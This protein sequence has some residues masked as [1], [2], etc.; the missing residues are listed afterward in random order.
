MRNTVL[1]FT[2]I[3][4]I[5][6]TL[7][8][9]F[10]GS[11]HATSNTQ[12][13]AVFFIDV[14]QGDCSIIACDG[15]IMM[16]DTGDKQHS[17]AVCSF[18]Q[19]ELGIDHIDYLLI[20]HSHNDH[21]GGLLG[22][23]D[24]CTL[25]Y[26][27][28]FSRPFKQE[29][30]SDAVNDAVDRGAVLLPLKAGDTFS[31]GSAEIEILGPLDGN[32]DS[33]NSRSLI[34]RVSYQRQSFLFTGDAERDEERVLL[35]AGIDLT[36]N[37]L[38]VPHHGA[39]ESN[40]YRFI[41]TVNPDYAIISVGK[42]NRYNH[43]DEKTLS[44]LEQAIDNKKHIL[45]TDEVGTIQCFTDGQS[46]SFGPDAEQA[47]EDMKPFTHKETQVGTQVG[48]AQQYTDAELQNARDA[49]QSIISNERK[50]LPG[51]KTE[52]HFENREGLLP[53]GPD[54]TEY[55][56]NPLTGER[57]DEYRIVLGSD[58]TAWYTHN[59]YSSFIRVR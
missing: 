28:T 30:I 8:L 45:R 15:M 50:A 25:D 34:F 51:Y 49:I 23:L 46:I 33:M 5:I 13:L 56:L 4:A 52:R 24:V 38:H 40:E 3:I 48:P 6:I 22:V 10:A 7:L 59:H 18:I 1:V 31:L 21:V 14:G 53:K 41:R 16:I 37:V 9:V 43:P 26:V 19:N 58:G 29:E 35:E 54:Y 32:N 42:G 20:T 36:A 57:R 44:V 11:S 17:Q 47:I 27:C 12:G 39:G 55:D 2:R